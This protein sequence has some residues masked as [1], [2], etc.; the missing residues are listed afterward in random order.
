MNR[1]GAITRDDAEAILKVAAGATDAVMPAWRFVGESAAV[2]RAES[3]SRYSRN[4]VPEEDSKALARAGDSAP[5]NFVGVLTGDV[6]G[7]WTPGSA[8]AA[9]ENSYDVMPVD[10]FRSLG[11]TPDTL[12]QWGIAPV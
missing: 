1:D 10:Y 11:L 6:D 9:P 2:A 7:S 3:G 4:S 5:I 8:Q 12:A